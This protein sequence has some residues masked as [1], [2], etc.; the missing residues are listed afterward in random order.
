[1]KRTALTFILLLLATTAR[2]EVPALDHSCPGG[3]RVQ[4]EAGGQ[5]RINGKV[6]RLR[7]FA[8]NY[9][10]AQGRGVTVSITAEPGGA[11][12]TYTTDDGAHGVCVPA[13]QAVDIAPEGPCSMAWNQ[14]VEARLGT[15]DGAGH[16]PD[17]GSDE[18]RFVVEKKLGL[19][20]KR[21]VPKRGSP[22][23]CRLVDGLVFR[24]PMPAKAQAPAFDCSTVEIGTPEGLVCTDP[25]LAALDRQL[26][27]VYKAALAKAGNERPPLLKAEQRGWAR[28]RHDCWKEADL[29]LC[30]QNA[31][32]RRI[33]ELQ[34]R[35]R[36]VPG[37]GPHRMICEGDPRNEVVVTYYATTPRT[38]VA[39]RGDQ[40]S[41]MFQEPDGALFVGR[42]E[43]LL[44][45]EGDVQVVWGFGAAPMSCVNRP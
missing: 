43:R 36:L 40:V 41:L 12:L 15:G 30:V 27:G 3:L 38:L 23:W 26:A 42:N 45:R 39:E 19:R 37:D 11:R 21:G 28:G 16:G 24:V 4:A 31:Y 9:W 34:A 13:A 10:E 14:R 33:A 18:W 17:V 32:V 25:E 44:Q 29:R 20:G 6:A 5:V 35:Y 7:Q 22:A 2:A 1:V 8:E